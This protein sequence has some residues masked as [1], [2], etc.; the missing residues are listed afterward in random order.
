MNPFLH[1]P[2]ATPQAVPQGISASRAT[3]WRRRAGQWVV[4]AGLVAGGPG[5]AMADTRATPAPPVLV[6]VNIATVAQ[7][8]TLKGIG[9]KTAA[10][11]VSERERAGPYVSFQDF[12]ERI[13]GIG[14]KR[15]AA[16]RE[17]GATVSSGPAPAP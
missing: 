8:E 9:P 5:M 7:L 16:L 3:P 6:N 2:V 17:A 10:L 13:R 14:P 4:A 15:A 12:A 11:I 1:A